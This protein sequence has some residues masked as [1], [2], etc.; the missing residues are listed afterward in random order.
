MTTQTNLFPDRP[1]PERHY[2][3]SVPTEGKDLVQKNEIASSQE[4]TI[5]QWFQSKGEGV[6]FT[7]WEV[8]N[9]A[10]IKMSFASVKRSMTNLMTNGF[11]AKTLELRPGE[12]GERHP[13]R[14]LEISRK[15]I[16]QKL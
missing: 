15:G 7:A 14:A 9:A 3:N 6:N 2:F 1:T 5:L 16:N 8:Y 13:N 12:F 10:G 11:L 4:R